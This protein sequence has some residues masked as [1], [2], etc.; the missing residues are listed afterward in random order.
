[1]VWPKIKSKR[2][3][4]VSEPETVLLLRGSSEFCEVWINGGVAWWLSIT[5]LS[6]SFVLSEQWRNGD[7]LLI[8]FS[9]LVWRSGVSCQCLWVQ[10]L[11][12]C[13]T[14]FAKCWKQ[15]L[16]ENCR[17]LAAIN[18]KIVL[19][20]CQLYES[21]GFVLEV[22]SNMEN[23]SLK[24]WTLSQ[25]WKLVDSSLAAI[26]S[27]YLSFHWENFQSNFQSSLSIGLILRIGKQEEYNSHLK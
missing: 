24:D 4:T 19:S 13:T 16:I 25:N 27:L 21:S 5:A 2:T 20:W 1:M 22:K 26:A 14:N 9:G 11:N 18:V 6:S 17:I 8:C 7:L 3:E 12:L 23:E 15:K 10:P